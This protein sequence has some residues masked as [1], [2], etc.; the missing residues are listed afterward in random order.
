M[1]AAETYGKYIIRDRQKFTTHDFPDSR[2]VTFFN[3][4][5]VYNQLVL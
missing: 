1:I 2:V 4:Q 3:K 5:P